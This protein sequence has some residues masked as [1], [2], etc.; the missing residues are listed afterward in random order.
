MYSLTQG[1]EIIG[2]AKD[3]GYKKPIYL[4]RT[5]DKK[6]IQLTSLLFYIVVALKENKDLI[7]AASSVSNFVNKYVDVQTIEILIKEKLA[8]LG[9]IIDSNSQ[10]KIQ[11]KTAP[12]LLLGL[13]FRFTLLSE[14]TTNVIADIFR[15]LYFPPV[16][17]IILLS[18]LVLNIWFFSM[19]SINAVF[20]QILNQPF[21]FLL[22]L[23][24]LI[25]SSLFHEIGHAAACKYGGGKAGRIGTGLYLIWPAFFT[26]VTD[27][28]RLNRAAKLRTDLGG[29]YFNAIFALFVAGGYFFTHFE[30]LLLLVLIQDTEILH[31]LLPFV[32]LDGYFIVSDI[33]GIPDLFTRIMPLLKSFLPG[34]QKNTTKDLKPWARWIVGLWILLTIPLL[35]YFLIVMI[36]HLPQIFL[37]TKAS[38]LTQMQAVSA[39]FI[40]GHYLLTIIQMLQLII[41]LLPA[42]GIL[43][44]LFRL[45]RTVGITL[46]NWKPVKQL[47]FPNPHKTH[48]NFSTS[49]PIIIF[50]ANDKSSFTKG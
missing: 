43:L 27:V 19:H 15:L 3:S 41:L 35:A 12:D 32:R 38:F 18:F 30:P 20:H 46:I 28:Y 26:D 8:P 10:N 24:L 47:F 16:V 22:V 25:V 40:Q 45:S 44:I 7:E 29:I 49:H 13:K 39:S 36:I 5:Q 33:I 2:R 48:N 50:Q 1:I 23:T 37:T 17:L 42:L 11:V 9:I 6:F 4:I 21:F 34:Q 14:N 31:Q